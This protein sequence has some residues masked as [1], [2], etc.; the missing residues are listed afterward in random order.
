MVCIHTVTGSVIEK[1]IEKKSLER[2][3]VNDIEK[4]AYR[5]R[6][7]YRE[8]NQGQTS[9]KPFYGEKVC[10]N[11]HLFLRSSEDLK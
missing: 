4:E 1:Y 2:D 3:K 6:G 9:Q 11:H 10:S 5:Y 8:K 7:K